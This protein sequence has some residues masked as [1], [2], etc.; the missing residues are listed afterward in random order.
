MPSHHLPLTRVIYP[1]SSCDLK[2]YSVSVF[3]WAG[4]MAQRV[5]VAVAKPGGLSPIPRMQMGERTELALATH[6]LIYTHTH[7]H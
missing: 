2:S 4:E 5:K 7:T 6:P 1:E 3:V